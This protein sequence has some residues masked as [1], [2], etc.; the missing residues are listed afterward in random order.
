MNTECDNIVR[1][2]V[3]AAEISTTIDFK[4]SN[5]SECCKLP[6][7]PPPLCPQT[8]SAPQI[9]TKPTLNVPAITLNFI[10]YDVIQ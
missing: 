10:I 3:H 4:F 7:A 2:P 5:Q 9:T 1:K 8:I 6:Q